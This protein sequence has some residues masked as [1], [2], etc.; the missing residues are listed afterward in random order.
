M[1]FAQGKALGRRG[2]YLLR[3]WLSFQKPAYVPFAQMNPTNCPVNY[4]WNIISSG[5][6][7]LAKQSLSRATAEQQQTIS[8]SYLYKPSIRFRE[9]YEFIAYLSRLVLYNFLTVFIVRNL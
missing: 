2:K 6:G 3:F 8:L 7:L 5:E 9:K 1:N 4:L